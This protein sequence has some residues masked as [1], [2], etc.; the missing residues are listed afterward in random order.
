MKLADLKAGLD[1]R[2]KVLA[3]LASIHE[4]DTACIAEVMA[5]CSTDKEARTYYVNRYSEIAA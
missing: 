1:D 4:T 2:S 5:Q 3:W